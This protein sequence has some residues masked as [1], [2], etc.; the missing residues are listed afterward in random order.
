MILFLRK[1]NL[2]SA[3]FTFIFNLEE[4]LVPFFSANYIHERWMNRE[5]FHFKDKFLSMRSAQNTPILTQRSAG[6]KV[7]FYEMRWGGS[8]GGRKREPL[9]EAP[10]KLSR[11]SGAGRADFSAGSAVVTF[12]GVHN[13]FVATFADCILRTFRFTSTAIDAIIG[14]GMSHFDSPYLFDNQACRPLEQRARTGGS[15]YCT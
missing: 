5:R 15:P 11:L 4:Q 3:L 1:K 6:A 7:E 2:G 9:G 13:I 12:G 10:R 8:R 14:N